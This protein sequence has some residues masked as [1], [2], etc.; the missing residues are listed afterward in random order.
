MSNDKYIKYVKTHVKARTLLEQFAEESAEGAKAAL[1]LIRAA[2]MSENPTPTT[3]Q[4][5]MDNL[6]EEFFD[7]AICYYLFTSKLPSL[8]EIRGCDKWQR[9]AKR[10]GCRE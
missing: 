8:E 1:K 2:E 9:W 7:I 6:K 5:A 10:L 4:E 3:L